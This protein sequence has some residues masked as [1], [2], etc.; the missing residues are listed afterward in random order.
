MNEEQHRIWDYL[1]ENAQGIDNSIHINVIAESIGVPDYGT[2]ND[3]VRNRIKDMVI[4]HGRPIGTC[5]DGAFI[6]LNQDELYAAVRFVDRNIR[7]EA[8]HRN[9][10]YQP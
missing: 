10:I 7:T 6:I 3:N 9:G 1:L 8:I 5:R 2:N 4:N